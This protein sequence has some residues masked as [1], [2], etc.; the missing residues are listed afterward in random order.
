MPTERKMNACT[1]DN[2]VPVI[3][4][5]GN[6]AEYFGKRRNYS[7]YLNISFYFCTYRLPSVLYLV[8][9]LYNNIS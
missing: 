4:S 8:Q 1:L 6:L 2:I 5:N 9:P 7:D 3:W